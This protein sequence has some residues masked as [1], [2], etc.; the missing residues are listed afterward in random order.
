M[1]LSIKK[2]IKNLLVYYSSLLLIVNTTL[3]SK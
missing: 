1:F 3:E 2:I